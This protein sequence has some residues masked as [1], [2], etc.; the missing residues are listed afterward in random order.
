MIDLL[1]LYAVNTGTYSVLFTNFPAAYCCPISSP[2][3]ML[4]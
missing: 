1:L 2:G 3:L 4:S